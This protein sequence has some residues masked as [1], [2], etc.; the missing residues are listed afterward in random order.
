MGVGQSGGEL[1]IA[2]VEGDFDQAGA[3]DGLNFQDPQVG[4]DQFRPRNRSPMQSS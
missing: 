3:L 2:G 4:V 1:G